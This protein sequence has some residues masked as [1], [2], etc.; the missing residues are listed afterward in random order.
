VDDPVVVVANFSDYDS[1]GEG[2]AEYRVGNW[3]GKPAGRRWRDVSQNRDVP[4]EWAG[5]EPL[6]PWE[7]KVYAAV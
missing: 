7:A 4:D 2:H 1:A 5:R 3:P 6:Y